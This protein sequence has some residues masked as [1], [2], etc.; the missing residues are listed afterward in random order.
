MLLGGLLLF[1]CSGDDGAPGPAGAKGDTGATGATGP[2]GP[3]GPEGPAGK[4]GQ[5]GQDA[6]ATASVEPE[7]CYICHRGV[8]YNKHQSIYDDYV[9]TDFTATV[10]NVASADN[11][12]GT[13]AV[14]V[15]FTITKFGL[16]YVDAAGLPS[17]EQMRLYTV[18]YDSATRM[19]DNSVRLS[20]GGSGVVPTGVD[21]EYQVTYTMDY[22]PESSN[23]EA[24]MYVADDTL[25][26]EGMTLYG[27]V[28]NAGVDYGNVDTY[29]SA[30]NVAGCEKCH[31]TPY[32]K[33]GYRAAA[34]A[35]L[36]DFASCKVCHTD[37][38]AGGH[39]DW[40]I[41]VDNPVRYAEIWYGDSITPEEEAYYAYK[42]NVK[43]DVHM[44][45][46]M[47]FPYPQLMANC[48]TCHEG[49][50]DMILTDDFFKA[51]TCRS[52]HPVTGPA[53]GTEP[54]RAPALKTLWADAGVTGIHNINQACVVCLS[55]IT[56]TYP[57]SK[58]LLLNSK[59]CI[60]AMTIS[61]MRMRPE[62]GI[63]MFLP[64]PSIR[65]RLQT[66]W[67]PLISVRQN[68]RILLDMM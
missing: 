38:T 46:A 7:S 54:H 62:P 61:S 17:L 9:D 8:G 31:G 35:G 2:A 13:F 44:S 58:R 51:E 37:S 60:P 6:T 28:A 27:N 22:A 55:V 65:H 25:N 39:E 49:K 34:V 64:C 67:L 45:H 32:R 42:R 19:F 53:S 18:M 36:P 3:T 41:L 68:P 48:A 47:E 24:Y 29:L 52:C 30:A 12:D 1:S 50:L 20:N 57:R 10:D 5:D 59:S 14:T 66:T 16:P 26:T 4:D 63:R 15:T 40:Q 23:A 43:N 56:T 33:H 11:G 21:G